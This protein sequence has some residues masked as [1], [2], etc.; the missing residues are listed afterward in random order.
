M[1]TYAPSLSAALF[2]AGAG[3]WDAPPETVPVSGAGY[4]TEWDY[5][6][7]E[8]RWA[9]GSNV[10]SG[11]CSPLATSRMPH[12]TR[13]E[14]MERALSCAALHET[15]CVLSAEIG[16]AV[17][18]AFIYD[19]RQGLRMV[20]APSLLPL[21]AP[22]ASVRLQDPGGGPSRTLRLN[23][24]IEVEYLDHEARAVVAE[25]LEGEAAYCVQLLRLLFEPACWRAVG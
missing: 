8:C 13:E 6:A 24:S 15:E 20:T 14:A 21:D 16:L 10:F 12:S 11:M 25:R 2:L 9:N 18:A 5:A 3:L 1:S 23:R 17:P 7:P 4:L 19:D 22:V